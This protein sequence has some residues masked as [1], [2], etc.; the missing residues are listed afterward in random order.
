VDKRST[1]IELNDQLRTTFKGGRVQM[2]RDLYELD[3]RSS[4]GVVISMHMNG[5]YVAI[6]A[7]IFTT[8]TAGSAVYLNFSL[9]QQAQ[10]FSGASVVSQDHKSESAPTS[11]AQNQRTISEASPNVIFKTYDN[12]KLGISVRIPSDW[13][14]YSVEFEPG[15]VALQSP[16]FHEISF[17]EQH[18]EYSGKELP[19]G[20][21]DTI[22]LGARFVIELPQEVNARLWQPIFDKKLSSDHIVSGDNSGD[23]YLLT[24]IHKSANNFYQY[25]I[26]FVYHEFTSQNR[27]ILSEFINQFQFLK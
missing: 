20:A 24:T 21:E 26:H 6:A 18:P 15:A 9:W 13:K 12:A 5:R 14:E 19:M 7:V 3:A 25:R 11:S 23:S 2:T 4:P 27:E 8:I 10:E 17:E 1:I 22:A 16:D